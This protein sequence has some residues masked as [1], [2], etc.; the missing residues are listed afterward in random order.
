MTKSE[1]KARHIQ[2]LGPRV[3]VRVVATEMEKSKGG[4]YL[5]VGTKNDTA[6]VAIIGE[7]VEV[8]RTGEDHMGKNVSGVPSGAK[9]ILSP[10]VGLQLP[11]DPSLRMVL[12]KDIVGTYEEIDGASLN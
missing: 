9:V 11:W 12:V 4:L 8:A 1:H 5:P 6:S 7:V 3:L 10:D 2:P